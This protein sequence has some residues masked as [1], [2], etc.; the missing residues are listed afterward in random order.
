MKKIILILL[1]IGI[2]F[3]L[4][5]CNDNDNETTTT[6]TTSVVNAQGDTST[7]TVSVDETDETTN[8]TDSTTM[9]GETTKKGD[10]TETTK[11]QNSV[12]A[13]AKAPSTAQEILKFYTDATAKAFNTK[14]GMTKSRG[15]VLNKYDASIALSAAKGLAF[16]F[17]GIGEKNK[18][19]ATIKK[20]AWTDNKDKYPLYKATMGISDISNAKCVASGK[21]Y[22]LTFDIKDASTYCEKGKNSHYTPLDKSGICSGFRDLTE[23]DHKN[24][25]SIYAAIKDVYGSAKISQ[26][27]SNAKLKAT[28]DSAS[29]KFVDLSI[30][31]STSVTI[32]AGKLVG[33]AIADGVSTI[34]YKSFVY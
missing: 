14:A 22:V 23:I 5:S 26:S 28:I 21:N 2:V 15:T 18:Y 24:A 33:K 17:M 1:S 7:T 32:D 4:S 10:T 29:G 12:N 6:E 13:P 31:F 16:E 9:I 20:G 27:Y 11:P 30:T 34:S 8:A 19:N 3:S 25:F